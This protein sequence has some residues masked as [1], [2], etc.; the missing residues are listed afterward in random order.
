MGEKWITVKSKNEAEARQQAKKK[1][2]ETLETEIKDSD[3]KIRREKAGIGDRLK[4]LQ[5]FRV[6][7]QDFVPENVEVNLDGYFK[8][9]FNDE[10]IMFRVH[11]P[12]GSGKPVGLEEV[13]KAAE[14]RELQDVDWE[15]VE[16]YLR[17]QA[18][19]Q[20]ESVEEGTPDSGEQAVKREDNRAES[21][22]SEEESRAEETLQKTVEKEEVEKEEDKEEK[23][24][25]KE[26]EKED[27]VEEEAGEVS[28]DI[29]KMKN[30]DWV[31]IAERRPELDRDAEVDIS[32]AD[33]GQKAFLDYRPPLGGAHISREQ[34]EQKLQEEGIVHGILAEELEKIPGAPAPLDNFLIARGT[35]PV[36]GKDG[37]LEY[38]FRKEEREFKGQLREDGSVDHYELDLINN[39]HKG[40]PVIT[41]KPPVPGKPGKTVTGKE[42]APD[43]NKEAVLPKGKN[44]EVS[45]DGQQ[46]LAGLDGQVIE[47]GPG[48]ISVLPVHQ[49]RGDVDLSTGNI[50]FLG[51]VIVDGNVTDG[52]KVEAEGEVE[53]RG[54][55]SGG[56]IISRSRVLIR[57]GYVG[58][59]KSQ[60][61][62]GED[63]QVK[64]VENGNIE[65]RGDVII[66]DAIMHSQV[67]TGGKIVVKGR[68][69]ISGGSIMAGLNVEAS[70]I[71]SSLAT[72]TE[73]IVG[74]DPEIREKYQQKLKDSQELSDNLNKIKKAV[75]LLEKA[76]E[77]NL[78]SEERQEQLQQLLQ[79]RAHLEKELKRVEKEKED[80]QEKIMTSRQGSVKVHQTLHPGVTIDI[81]GTRHKVP[82]KRGRTMLVLS[83]GDIAYRT[84]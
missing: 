64:F 49:V 9:R 77:K 66:G 80:L 11:A 79:T 50:K 24:E 42:I 19:P 52:F 73:V 46:L 27:T 33:D 43:K 28:E 74:V 75:R 30:Q 1:L 38:H 36:Q 68:G 65:A 40:D 13:K 16:T 63:V 72:R 84:M 35:D 48:R 81:A 23:V 45:E 39:V 31:V 20:P 25:D 10:G 51:A 21:G 5:V 58:K 7:L 44:V 54:S 29:I 61:K 69:L 2:Q 59:G 82:E 83:G 17:Y 6:G 34:L 14:K 57:K 37:F 60:I 4:G 22:L 32:L 76:A 71:G 56:T 26:K 18:Q 62:S 70:V 8:L 67:S 12:K 3:L 15:K 41:L 55:V 53:V 78:L 47:E